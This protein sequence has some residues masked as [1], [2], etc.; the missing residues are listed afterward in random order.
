MRIEVFPSG[1]GDC[2]LITS[3]DDKRL[4]ADA[5]LPDAFDEFIATPL[6]ELRKQQK[7]IDVA[8]ISH[9]DRDHIGG[10]LRMLVNYV[11]SE[12][13][14]GIG[15]LGVQTIR[16]KNHTQRDIIRLYRNKDWIAFADNSTVKRLG[17]LPG[18]VTKLSVAEWN[19]IH[20]DANAD[21][22]RANERLGLQW[23]AWAS[24]ETPSSWDLSSEWVV[25]STSS[26][27]FMTNLLIRF[28]INSDPRHLTI[29]PFELGVPGDATEMTLRL[30][31]NIEGFEKRI[32]FRFAQ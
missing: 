5:G 25:E 22:N 31:S 16:S 28:Q 27:V 14:A 12:V 19:A 30:H 15:Y 7:A 23:H 29:I 1:S 32:V 24:E 13:E 11:P 17:I 26:N 8:Y 4:L 2:V 21:V 6:A 3:S 18:P 10:V 20:G 9:I